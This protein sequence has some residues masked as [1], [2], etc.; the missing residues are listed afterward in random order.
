[1]TWTALRAYQPDP[2]N[3]AGQ[4]RL[5]VRIRASGQLSGRLE[6]LSALVKQ[7]I[8]VWENGAW[9]ALKPSSNPAWAFRWYA[10]GLRIGG[11]L[12]AGA[13]LDP[14]RVDE[15]AIKAWG[16]WCDT[17][18]LEC[19]LVI[20][21]AMT[22]AE[23]LNLIAQCG[24]ASLSW[25]TGKLGAVWDQAGKPVTALI[26]PANVIAGSFEVE[27]AA[28]DKAA[29]EIVCRYIEPDLDW[30]WHTVRR[31]VPGVSAPSRSATLTLAG[32]TS[33]QQA[34]M[35]CNLQAARQRYHRR[36]L[37]FE[38]ASEG[39][40][41]ARGDVVYL[42]HGLIDGGAAGRLL[43]GDT[44]RLT[45]SRSVT[46]SGPIGFE[47][48]PGED[49]LLLRLPDG[50]LHT[51][52]LIHP[53]GPHT[54][55]ETDVVILET[56]L[57][58]A[59][60]REGA[61]PLDT[62]WRFYSSDTPPA[63]VRITALEPRAGGERIRSSAI[64]EVAEYHAA[65]TSDLSVALPNI[66]RRR[67]RVLAIELS[68]EL[69]PAGSNFL[70]QITAS[71]TV[72]GPWRE[73]HVRVSFDGGELRTV[74]RLTGGETETFWLAPPTGVLT[75]TALPGTEVAPLGA[76]LCTSMGKP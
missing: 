64:D 35:E 30:Q 21:R 41:I 32:V 37:S 67:A 60:E 9:S 70:V 40:A 10:L 3:Y 61:H 73:G 65:A 38:M 19:N 51:S 33:R 76:G 31:T 63:K 56:P 1:M 71:L 26:T 72:S 2:G 52:R 20:D 7:K 48:G 25:Q 5:A 14:A 43:A 50:T 18:K 66:R 15:E 22:H 74:A 39:F 53:D 12:A 8:P 29:E 49:F 47:P 24:R 27:W 23:V 54:G 6:K 75:V 62:L 36:T 42:T 16:A 59:P 58:F 28:S 57:P 4:T 17:Q 46:L 34:A 13:G 55:G 44:E 11:R 45:L 69:I 68:E